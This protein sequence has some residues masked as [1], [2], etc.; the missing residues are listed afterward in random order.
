M[1]IKKE[2]T[3]EIECDTDFEEVEGK[4][5]EC[6][7]DKGNEEQQETDRK[8]NEHE[9]QNKAEHN[10]S[11][12]IDN[13][14]N[15]SLS[16]GQNTTINAPVESTVNATIESTDNV[17][18]VKETRTVKPSR[19]FYDRR[20]KIFQPLSEEEKKLIEYIRSD[21]FPEGD[22]VFAKKGLELECLWFLSLYLEIKVA[23]NVIDAWSDVLNHEEKYKVNCSITSHVYCWTEM[24]NAEIDII[25]NINNNVEDMSVR[26][27]A[28]A[29]ALVTKE[30]GNDGVEKS[31]LAQLNAMISKLESMNDELFD[32]LM[33]LRDDK[34]VK[35]EKLSLLNEM[36]AMVEEDIA[37]KE[38][39]VSSG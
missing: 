36:I 7:E 3:N 12:N 14:G 9:S 37:T 26:Y 25:D 8:S 11:D 20:V 30:E 13:I 5:D 1:G 29:M 17:E 38:A 15:L 22:I 39:H 33:C 6:E 24:L 34:R 21:S 35:S 23:E 28:Y 32:S 4:K 18:I 19:N 16:A 27:A 31:C 2:N 10:E